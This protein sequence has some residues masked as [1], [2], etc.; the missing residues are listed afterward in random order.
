LIGG[1]ISAVLKSRILTY[2]IVGLLS[3]LYLFIFVLIQLEDYALLIGSLGIFVILALVMY[4]SRKI[5]WYA[6]QRTG[7]NPAES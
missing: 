5:D 1:Y 3:V 7:N 2:F 4:Y 6:I